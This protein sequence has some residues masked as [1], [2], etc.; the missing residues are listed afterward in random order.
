MKIASRFNENV[1][2][3]FSLDLLFMY[4]WIYSL[5]DNSVGTGYELLI[6]IENTMTFTS[7]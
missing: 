6:G 4:N 5:L 7:K 2:K 3:G 1:F